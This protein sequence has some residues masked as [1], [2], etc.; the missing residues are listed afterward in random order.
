MQTPESDRGTPGSGR[1]QQLEGDALGVVQV[2]G[3]T[4]RVGPLRDLRG[5]VS[6]CD[7]QLSHPLVPVVDVGDEEGEM[8][9]PRLVGRKS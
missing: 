2:T 1:L 3:P 5:R 9:D 6:E 4:T 7:A 8:G